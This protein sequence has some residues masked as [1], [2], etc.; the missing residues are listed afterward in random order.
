MSLLQWLRASANIYYDILSI[1][2]PEDSFQI[3]IIK[4]FL[5]LLV[6]LALLLLYLGLFLT[7]ADFISPQYI[8]C[9]S[10]ADSL[11]IK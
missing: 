9:L 3:Y 2:F 6:V 1:L 5:L 4:I 7:A 10:S 8:V 11:G